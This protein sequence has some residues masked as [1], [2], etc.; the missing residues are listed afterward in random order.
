VPDR[1]G[2]VARRREVRR[3]ETPTPY[4]TEQLADLRARFAAPGPVSC[5]ACGSR[6]A[7]DPAQR[8]GKEVARGVLCVGCGRA[9]VVPRSWASRVLVITHNRLLRSWLRETL[10]GAGHYV[11]ETDDTGVALAAYQVAEADVIIL[12]VV[13]PG[14]VP[15]P[16]FQRQLR[17]T[18]PDA[19]IVALAGRMSY[20]GVDPLAVVPGLEAVRSIRVPITREALLKTVEE[21]R[22]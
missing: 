6:V 14:R 10:A 5:P 15:V 11:V 18:F 22:A 19:R 17:A 9:A 16:E 4:T 7:L 20:E 21:A 3:R 1:R 13:T 8:G 2:V 12:D